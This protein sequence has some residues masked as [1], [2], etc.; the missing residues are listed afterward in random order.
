MKSFPLQWQQKKLFTF[1]AL[2]VLGAI[3]AIFFSNVLHHE[4]MTLAGGKTTVFNRT[5]SA[6]EQ[7]SAGLSKKAFD[8]HGEG[9]IAFEAVFVTSPAQVNPGLGPLF[10]NASCVGCHI[11][12]GR[13]LPEKGQLLVRVS[14]TEAEVP[15]SPTDLSEYHL[16][17]T[18]PLEN[19]PSVPGLGTQIQDQ[20]IYG[21]VPE[22]KVEIQWREQEGKYGDG[23]IYKLRSPE[24]KITLINGELLSPDI[25]TSL[26]IP[27]PV[28]GLGLLEAVPEKTIRDLADPEDK[29]QDGISGR[30]NEVWDVSTQ[31]VAMGRFGLKANQPNLLQQTA[32]AY[33]NDMG[34]TNS[35]FPAVDGSTDIDRETLENAAFYVQT[36][37]VPARTLLD[38]PQVQR[39]E[40]LFAE[41]NCG[42]CHVSELGT[43]K[44]EVKELAHQKIH[45]YTD[46]L[47]HDMGAGLADNRPD[48]QASGS[49][50]RTPPLWGI[51]LTQTVLP[52]SSY[53]HDGRARTLEE[54]ILWHGGEAEASKEAFRNMPESDR[55]ALVRFLHS[56]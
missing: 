32:A 46:M 5:S 17:G 21:K 18:V 10:N 34:V 33:V 12:N 36:L 1:L 14:G 52:Y 40:K 38:D 47:L 50:W 26:R 55:S 42:A 16:E 30:P 9:D 53:L 37:A 27:P 45:P 29:N 4:E 20:G 11:R 43:G 15:E 28:F 31:S 7:P 22:A 6:Y 19:T 51:G 56:L 41:T 39:G 25:M 3:L 54:A 48:F 23:T 24:P 35:L 49:E 8:K 13:G 2:F 44:Y